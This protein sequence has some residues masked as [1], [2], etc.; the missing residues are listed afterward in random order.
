MVNKKASGDDGSLFVGLDSSTQGLKA[1]LIDSELNVVY[2]NAVNFDMDLPEFKTEGGT[3]HHL[4]GLTVTAPPLMWVAA[5]D[6]LFERMK[7]DNCPPEKVVAISGS[8]Q[9]HGS[10]WLKK[11][12]RDCLRNLDSSKSLREQL[13]EAFSLTDSPIWMDSSTGK[14][15]EQREKALGGAQAVADLTGSRA[16]ERFTGNQIAKIFQTQPEVYE[17]TEQIALVS[18]FMASL[19]IGDYAPIDAGD[20][21][22]MNLMDLRSKKWAAVALDCTAPGLE[23]KLGAIVQSHV[24]IGKLHAFYVEKF[25]FRNDCLVVAFSGDN[26]NSLAGLR[27]QHP[28]D[29]AISLGTSDTVFG[30]LADPAPSE[31]EGHIFVNPIDPNAY[32]ALVCYK[33][34]SL[35]REYVRDKFTDGSWEA[36]NEALRETA[37]GNNGNIGFYIK[38]PEITPTI[39]KTGIFRFDRNDSHVKSFPPASDVR[40]VV[41][42]QFFSMRLHGANIGLKPVSVLATGGASS[43]EDITRVMSNVLGVPVYVGEQ[44]NSASLGAA[45][46]ALHGWKCEMS[47]RFVPFAEVLAG[48][49]PFKKAGE[50][51]MKAYA[52]Y[53]E[54]LKRYEKLE[55][56]VI[57]GQ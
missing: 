21:A 22:G 19:L 16:Y 27:L 34:G 48:A 12:A 33:N 15:C 13:T 47:G 32:M 53:T 1:T 10:V 39:L 41:E 44:P 49:P 56:E 38:E 43:N 20:G 8:G 3:H 45:Y 55:R 57:S 52:A 26:P 2:E 28:G 30:S 6:L 7:A 35:T 54:I 50:P 37:P 25:G 42:G 14:Q 46:R 5:L 4:D 29:I 36:F 24:V 17:A 23:E 31:S 9:Q 18:S 11:G 40:A 51:D